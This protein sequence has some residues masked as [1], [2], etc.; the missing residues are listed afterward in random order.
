MKA[1]SGEK[2]AKLKVVE[3]RLNRVEVPLDGV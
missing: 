1:K 2:D 3:F